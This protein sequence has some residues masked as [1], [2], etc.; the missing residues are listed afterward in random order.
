MRWRE[1]HTT[2]TSQADHKL[3]LENTA[4]VLGL[5]EQLFGPVVARSEHSDGKAVNNACYAH[6]EHD[7][8]VVS[9]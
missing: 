7:A 5:I 2:H 1:R 8:M 4:L 6:R 3:N 9:S